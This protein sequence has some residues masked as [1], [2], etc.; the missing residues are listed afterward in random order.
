MVIDF[1]ASRVLGLLFP[2]TTIAIC[3]SDF[4]RSRNT[5]RGLCGVHRIC[6]SMLRQVHHSNLNCCFA[7]SFHTNFSRVVATYNQN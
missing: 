3:S 5:V 7:N 6:S 1:G 4:G 2:T